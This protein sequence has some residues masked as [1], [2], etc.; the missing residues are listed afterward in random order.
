[1]LP[2]QVLLEVKVTGVLN[3]QYVVNVM[4]LTGQ[5]DDEMCSINFTD[6]SPIWHQAGIAA[7][8]DELNDA[9]GGFLGYYLACCP[10]DFEVRT[11]QLRG[12]GISNADSPPTM[13][14]QGSNV[15]V[16][17]GADLDSQAG[18]RT[19]H[20]SGES[21]GPGVSFLTSIARKVG[22]AFF[23]GISE[24]DANQGIIAS[25]LLTAIGTFGTFLVS[26][27]LELNAAPYF[28]GVYQRSRTLP[29]VIT[30]SFIIASAIRIGFYI[31][32][33]RKRRLPV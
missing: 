27:A 13:I 33:Q 8:L 25:G 12:V 28:F 32:N 6:G 26:G 15:A 16:I 20:T 3:G 17:A 10:E 29:T 1:M 4:H 14:V 7:A 24:D 21:D 23:P 31:W 22:K 30:P 19:G 11:M 18:T 9:S 5:R 2:D